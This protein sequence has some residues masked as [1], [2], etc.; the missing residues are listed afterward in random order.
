MSG[1][2]LRVHVADRDVDVALEI[3]AGETVAVIGANGA[4]KSTLLEALAGFLRPDRGRIVLE[5]ETLLDT[6]SSEAVPPHRRPV[7]LLAQEALL[8]PHLTVR[9]NVAFPLR[10]RLGLARPAAAVEAGRRLDALGAG[11]LAQR[12]PAQLSGGQAQRVALVRALAADPRLLL[13]DEPLAALDATAVPDMRAALRAAASGRT[14]LVVTHDPL[15][16]LSLAER[17]VVIERGRVVQQGP[18]TEVLRTP[19][20]EFGR[21][22]LALNPWIAAVDLEALRAGLGDD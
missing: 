13:L 4:G 6:E 10:H 16:A 20:S 15:D 12:R 5:G 11:H 7:A 8:F 14:A 3:G 1:L 19:R 18:P 21:S 2:E 17:V 9:N 22:L